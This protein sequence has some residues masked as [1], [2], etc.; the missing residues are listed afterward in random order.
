MQKTMVEANPQNRKELHHPLK[1]DREFAGIRSLSHP[2]NV[3][4]VVFF[5]R[6]RIRLSQRIDLANFLPAFL[7]LTGLVVLDLL[8]QLHV[9]TQ[10][11][12]SPRINL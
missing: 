5:L 1:G 3:G 4:C 10:H 11:S 7:P 12:I 9:G 2:I 6:P 8:I